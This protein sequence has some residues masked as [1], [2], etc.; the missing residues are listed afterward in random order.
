LKCE[1]KAIEKRLPEISAALRRI[2]GSENVASPWEA[3]QIITDGAAKEPLLPNSETEGRKDLASS[4]NGN[5]VVPS[6]MLSTGT[7]FF[8]SSSVARGVV[9]SFLPTCIEH[10]ASVLS[11]LSPWYPIVSRLLPASAPLYRTV[12]MP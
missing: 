6:A 11:L 8:T 9:L 7:G 10:D 4:R 5:S 1:P 12:Q 2:F 3:D